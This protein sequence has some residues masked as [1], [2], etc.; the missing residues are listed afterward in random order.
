MIMETL[1]MNIH[2]VIE[3]HRKCNE[4]LKQVQ[5]DIEM[6]LLSISCHAELVSASNKINRPYILARINS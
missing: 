3:Q 4:I 6:M 2:K 5:D 1:H